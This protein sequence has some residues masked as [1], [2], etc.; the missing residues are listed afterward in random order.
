MKYLHY[1]EDGSTLVVNDTDARPGVVRMVAS[2]A[3]INKAR[4][5]YPNDKLEMCVPA[6]PDIADTNDL[7]RVMTSLD[8]LPY[9]RGGFRP[10]TDTEMAIHDG[11]AFCIARDQEERFDGEFGSDPIQAVR[12]LGYAGALDLL[13]TDHVDRFHFIVEKLTISRVIV[14]S[15]MLPAYG[16]AAMSRLVDPRLHRSSTDLMYV[17]TG[18][19]EES[20]G[21]FSEAVSELCVLLEHDDTSVCK[22][23][24]VYPILTTP[25]A[26]IGFTK[27]QGGSYWIDVAKSMDSSVRD[28]D[29]LLAN[30][31]KYARVIFEV[32]RHAM[33]YLSLLFNAYITGNACI[34]LSFFL[35]QESAALMMSG[36][37][38]LIYQE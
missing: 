16:L 1:T 23:L 9:E 14:M 8:G 34:P 5:L 26:W 21:L 33:E 37:A 24:A 25:M 27:I 18:L 20:F 17:E 7:L 6:R 13:N 38:P 12:K 32:S 28:V 36:L 30:P 31:E 22:C 4:S 10:M 11:C 29:D 15:C 35:H 2:I 19:D 3:N